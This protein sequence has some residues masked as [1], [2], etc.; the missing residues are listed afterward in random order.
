MKAPLAW[1]HLSL[2]VYLV[3]NLCV[4][5]LPSPGF[6][7]TRLPLQNTRCNRVRQWILLGIT[8]A[9]DEPRS[10]ELGMPRGPGCQGRPS[11]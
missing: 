2:R 1:A 6:F 8:I 5:N 11:F 9:L 7:Y 4:K 3:A 10:G